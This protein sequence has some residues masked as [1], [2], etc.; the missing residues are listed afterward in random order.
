M[1]A[2]SH[3]DLRRRARSALVGVELLPHPAGDVLVDLRVRAVGLGDHDREAVVRRG[4]DVEMQRYLAEESHAELFGLLARAAM[5]ED[6]RPLAALGAEEVAHVL[7][8]PE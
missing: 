4:A 2:L 6:L 5:A 8:D 3:H 1:N 7:D